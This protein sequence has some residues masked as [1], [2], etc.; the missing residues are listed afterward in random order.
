LIFKLSF[1]IYFC[2]LQIFC[3]SNNLNLKKGKDSNTES[4]I[5]SENNNRLITENGYL[6]LNMVY[7]KNNENFNLDFIYFDQDWFFFDSTKNF[8]F[9]FS[10]SNYQILQS[11]GKITYSGDGESIYFKAKGKIHIPTDFLNKII[12]QKI[13]GLRI[14]GKY[15]FKEYKIGIDKMQKRWKNMIYDLRKNNISL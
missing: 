15:K 9:L 11:K 14:N 6:E 10:D 13:Y 4:L 5:I 8:M 2:L 3:F 7:N 1:L 12:D